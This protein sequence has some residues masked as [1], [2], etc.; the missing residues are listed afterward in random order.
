MR[1]PVRRSL[2]F[3][4]LFTSAA[5]AD[6]GDWDDMYKPPPATRRSGFAAG[7]TFAAIA[8]SV[9]GYPREVQKIGVPQYEASTGAAGGAGGGFWLGGAVR[10]WVVVGV[11][12]T[13]GTIAG[14]GGTLSNGGAFVL[15]LEGFPLASGSGA[16]RDLGIVGEFGAG[17]RDVF[18]GSKQGADGGSTSYAAIGLLYEPLRVGHVSIGPTLLLGHQFSP[19]LTATLVSAGVQIAFYGG[20]G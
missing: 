7:L 8:G 5:K 20:P 18:V 16:F 4:L 19:T 6:V 17:S 3:L 12:A 15:H 14:G 13:F 2:L 11:G 10:D 9:S 1:L